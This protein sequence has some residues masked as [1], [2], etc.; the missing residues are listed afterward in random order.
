MAKSA[1]NHPLQK[2]L[3]PANLQSLR[4]CEYSLTVE[5]RRPKILF[6]SDKIR[7]AFKLNFDGTKTRAGSTNCPIVAQ[8]SQE[9]KIENDIGSRNWSKNRS[10]NDGDCRNHQIH[11]EP[12]QLPESP[13]LQKGSKLR[14]CIGGI[15][16][17]P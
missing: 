13:A 2:L 9:R 8:H 3:Q 4:H 7:Q 5:G 16:A 10:E 6:E 17:G 15:W 1:L 14:V 12:E 11:N